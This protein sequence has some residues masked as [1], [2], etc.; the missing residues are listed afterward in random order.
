MGLPAPGL[1]APLPRHPPAPC[2][3]PPTNPLVLPLRP[4]GL[5]AVVYYFTTGRLL[6]AWLVLSVLLPGFLVQ[7][8]SYLWF[9]EDGRQ[10]GCLL[11]VL[12][13]LQLGVWKR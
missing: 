2:P 6:W 4:P 9:R 11:L 1:D 13:L 10:G 8:L 7:G 3:Q 5:C 12:H